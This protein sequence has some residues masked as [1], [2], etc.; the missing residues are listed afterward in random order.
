M[1][2]NSGAGLPSEVDRAEKPSVLHI[3]IAEKQIGSF[4]DFMEEEFTDFDK[5]VF[6]CL[7]DETRHPLRRR[8]NI[9]FESDYRRA[10]SAYLELVRQMYR[11]NK[12]IL[13]G[14][15]SMWVV[16][17]LSIQPWLL[18]KCYWV[19][20]GADLYNHRFAHHDLMWQVKE[21]SRRIVIKR[22]GHLITYVEGD[23][24]L[25]RQWYGARG[26]H[27]ECLMYPSNLYKDYEVPAKTDSTT[28]IQIGNSADPGNEHF[29]MLKML[30][31]YKNEDIRIYA[32][33]NYG[34][35]E[36]ARKVAQAGSKMFGSKFVAITEFMPLEDYI[37]FLGRID[38]AIFNHRR[39]QAMGNI[40]TLLGLGKK[41]FLRTDITSWD[42][43]GK[44]G[45]KLY[46]S[47]HIDLGQIDVSIRDQNR[48]LV[49]ANFSSFR[50]KEELSEIF[51]A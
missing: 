10:S 6:F 36:H 43:F 35:E 42:V 28:R 16:R 37:E 32:P 31:V 51:E 30:E 49:K 8:S 29:E 15:W 20:W 11:A 33:L 48:R 34:P 22:I 13:H 21:F 1:P 3:F 5:H 9:L 18:P 27:H 40:I 19:I 2:R 44:I 4:V 23:A 41:V 12:I 24:D 14:L 50:L 38:I 47:S 25:A 17:L 7:G 46:D 39:Q 26:Q 45:V